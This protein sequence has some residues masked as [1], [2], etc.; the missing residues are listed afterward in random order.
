MMLTEKDKQFIERWE[1]VREK[2]NRIQS[3][4]INGLPMAVLFSAPILLFITAV[5]LFFPEWYTKVS[6]RLSG[7]LVTIVI[8]VVLCILF[9]SYFRM[10]FKWEMNDQL[11]RELKSKESKTNQTDTN[12]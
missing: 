3:K 7:S 9:Y 10:H 2:E 6:N 11:Y 12:F 5:Y 1:R 4:L 8:A